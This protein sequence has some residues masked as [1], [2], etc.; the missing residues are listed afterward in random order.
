VAI[1]VRNKKQLEREVRQEQATRLAYIGTLAS[2]LAHEIR[3]PLNAIKLNLDLLREDLGAVDPSRHSDFSGRL[4]L[5]S[6][7]V[8]GLQELLTEF[9]NFAKPPTMEMLPTDLNQLLTDVLQFIAPACQQRQIKIVTNFQK[10]LYP[11]ALDQNQFG[12]GVILNLLTNA[13]EQ[14]GEHGTIVVSTRET[15]DFVE[16]SVEDNGGGVPPELEPRIF[17]VFFS[18]KAHGTGLGLA[19]ARRIVQEHGGE[20]LLENHPKRG[21]TFIVRLRKSMILELK[22]RK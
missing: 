10:E 15:P 20:L 6:R 11:V 17:E 4:G 5:I 16:V 21:A 8:D 12:R 13:M 9:L 19:I 3:S 14:I 2:G 22:E 18:T 7:E 1:P